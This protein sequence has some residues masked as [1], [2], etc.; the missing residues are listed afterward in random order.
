MTYSLG[1]VI[2]SNDSYIDK[3]KISQK[4]FLE[5]EA[6]KC[7]YHWRK[8]G[9]K[10]KDIDIYCIC[11]TKNTP[12][13]KTIKLLQDQNVQYIEH[14]LE[15]TETFDCGFYNKVLGCKIIE[16]Y[17]TTDL[18]IHIDLDMYL[19]KEPKIPEKNS[20]LRYD[21]IQKQFERKHNLE[22]FNTCFIVSEYGFYNLWWDKLQSCIKNYKNLDVK[23]LDFRKIEELSFDLLSED[24]EIQPLDDLIFGE[25]Y[26]DFN[27]IEN[28]DNVCFHCM[29]N[30]VR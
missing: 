25:T 16:N 2:E 19:I 4:R 8:F 15:I 30:G 29:G 24:I 20:C 18:L 14:Y 1:I 22:I 13:K 10:Y 27:I 11:I 21:S 28:K 7:V 17:T 3:N 9:G 26:T 23:D 12:C 6:L 5:K